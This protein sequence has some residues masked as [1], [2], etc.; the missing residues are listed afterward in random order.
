MNESR[1]EV[2]RWELNPD[3]VQ[4]V[5]VLIQECLESSE[6][7]VQY[8][9]RQGIDLK[10]KEIQNAIID[11]SHTIAGSDE[12][13]YRQYMLLS[14]IA[15]DLVSCCDHTCHIGQ[16]LLCPR[17]SIIKTAKFAPDFK[18]KADLLLWNIKTTE[19]DLF[20]RRNLARNLLFG[21][22]REANTKEE[23]NLLF[24]YIEEV[25]QQLLSN[26]SDAL[27]LKE[28]EGLPEQSIDEFISKLFAAQK[29]EIAD[30][31]ESME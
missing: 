14:K 19:D 11:W 5:K 17:K 7:P 12:E 10:N 16:G 27:K 4:K 23:L 20:R 13:M 9:E 3:A 8:A 21:L 6:D 26:K 24:Q 28:K 31:K 22:I 25:E 1:M 18:R 2:N 30:K 15:M 29:Q